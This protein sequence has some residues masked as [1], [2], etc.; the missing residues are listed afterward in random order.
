MKTRKL[1]VPLAALMLISFCLAPSANAVILGPVA[2]VAAAGVVVASF[3]NAFAKAND[4]K[5]NQ[6]KV[7]AAKLELSAGSN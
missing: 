6:L 1:I 5:K 7:D 4:V 2:I 3:F